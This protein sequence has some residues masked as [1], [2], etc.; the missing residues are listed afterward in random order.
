MKKE[1]ALAALVL[2]SL[3]F[4]SIAYAATKDYSKEHQKEERQEQSADQA[5]P[6]DQNVPAG[7]SLSKR[8]LMKLEQAEAAKKRQETINKEKAADTMPK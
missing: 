4:S 5:V 8:N 6:S 1:S 3:L 7:A 2:V